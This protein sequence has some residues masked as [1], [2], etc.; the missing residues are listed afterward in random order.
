MDPVSAFGLAGAVVQMLGTLI[1]V[2]DTI[3]EFY[4]SVKDGPSRLLEL[5][6]E[7]L[8]LVGV[9][10]ILQQTSTL[11]TQADGTT[12]HKFPHVLNDLF[13]LTDELGKLIIPENAKGFR[14]M[15][16]SK[17]D[18]EKFIARIERHKATLILA[19]NLEQRSTLFCSSL[20]TDQTHLHFP[21]TTVDRWF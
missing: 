6:H 19:M 7:L 17:K 13:A 4:K 3:Y 8:S 1:K 11:D 10:R 21:H 2:G 15:T 12:V 20:K 16:G 9:L 18:I 14:R 5:R